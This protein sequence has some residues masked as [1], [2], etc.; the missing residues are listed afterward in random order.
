MG[1]SVGSGAGAEHP[2][3]KHLDHAFG[4]KDAKQY[5]QRRFKGYSHIR[6]A[7]LA[8]IERIPC[9]TKIDSV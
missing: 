2:D 4:R 6:V 9:K 8:F 3:L 1:R 7:G 5:L